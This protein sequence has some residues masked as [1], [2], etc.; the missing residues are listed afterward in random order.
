[1]HSYSNSKVQATVNVLREIHSI[2]KPRLEAHL[3]YL[4]KDPERKTP[5]PQNALAPCPEVNKL[6]GN[7]VTICDAEYTAIEAKQI[8]KALQNIAQDLRDISNLSEGEMER[9]A[10]N[11]IFK[12][13]EKDE[14]IPYTKNKNKQEKTRCLEN[15]VNEIPKAVKLQDVPEDE[16]FSFPYLKNYDVMAANELCLLTDDKKIP[17]LTNQT[18]TFVGAGFPL[19]AIMY[20]IHSGAKINLVDIDPNACK[21]AEQFLEICHKAGVLNNN[22]FTVIQGNACELKY[23]KNQTKDFSQNF[24]SVAN[25]DKNHGSAKQVNTDILVFAAALPSKVK[26]QA[27]A[28]V[29]PKDVT[30]INRCTSE[31]N[32]LL[33]PS[34]KLSALIKNND[35]GKRGGREYKVI[36]VMYPEFAFKNKVQDGV[37]KN[38]VPSIETDKINQN[39]AQRLN[40]INTQ[41][42]DA[43][44]QCSFASLEGEKNGRKYNNKDINKDKNT[45][46]LAKL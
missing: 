16:Q 9:V 29:S 20:H 38:G 25:V 39:T 5:Y 1:M 4:A 15:I 41:M 21:R 32:N 17:N 3:E 7:L 11:Y 35:L 10:L 18:I 28:N 26:A 6:L 24:P 46:F 31:V 34:T 13:F 14:K 27:L 19:S 8:Q 33:Y 23:S 36:D 22:D 2:M 30:V 45:S 44:V 42:Q 12:V 43:G 37:N 40:I